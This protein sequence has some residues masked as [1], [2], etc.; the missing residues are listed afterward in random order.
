MKIKVQDFKTKVT[1]AS[2]DVKYCTE[3]LGDGIAESK[4]YH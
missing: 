1:T 2:K 4:W 3:K